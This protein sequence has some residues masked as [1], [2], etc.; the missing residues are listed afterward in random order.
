MWQEFT[1]AGVETKIRSIKV[2][3]L[4]LTLVGSD[5]SWV[6]LKDETM[7]LSL[8]KSGLCVQK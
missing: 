2:L 7:K 1:C 6:K 8:E 4:L 3:E 5:T